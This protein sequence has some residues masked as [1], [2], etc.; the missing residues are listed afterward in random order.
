MPFVRFDELRVFRAAET[1]ADKIWGI[2]NGWDTF[3]K[4]TIGKQLVRSSDSIG[5][6]IAEG[7]GRGATKD[8]QRFVRMA[9]GSLN[10]TK[11]WLRRASVRKLINPDQM[12]E[13]SQAIEKMGLSL[14]AYLKS[15]DPS[16]RSTNS[17][18]PSLDH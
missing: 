5:A 16:N 3:A 15:L 14:N 17:Q 2:V 8:N 11:Y 12:L 6:N 7:S 10:E 9:R 18:D 13:L 4:L 1:F